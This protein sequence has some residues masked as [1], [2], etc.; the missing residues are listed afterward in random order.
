[1]PGFAVDGWIPAIL[2]ALITSLV[3]GLVEGVLRDRD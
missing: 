2:G 1:V 3:S